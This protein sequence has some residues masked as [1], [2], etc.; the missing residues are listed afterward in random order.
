MAMKNQPQVSICIP[1]YNAESTIGDTIRSLIEQTYDNIEIVVVNDFSTDATEKIVKEFT[2]PRIRF[3]NNEHNLGINANWQKTLLEANGKYVML[4]GHDDMLKPSCVE[5]LV[6]VFEHH[7]HVGMVGFRAQ[8]L[9]QKTTSWRPVYGEI[10]PSALMNSIIEFV[11]ITPPSEIMYR[12]SAVKEA[13]GYDPDYNYSPEVTLAMKLALNNWHTINLDE[14][15]GVRTTYPDRVTAVVSPMVRLK[16]KLKF[17]KDYHSH[18][19]LK[20]ILSAL[21]S[22]SI[23]TMRMYKRKIRRSIKR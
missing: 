5:R 17:I 14:V 1:A 3:I 16:D 2:D 4:L 18:Y 7:E 9:P 11:N 22:V 19:S 6:D 20:T 13:G 10:T 21:G 12:T 23:D 8:M 15:L